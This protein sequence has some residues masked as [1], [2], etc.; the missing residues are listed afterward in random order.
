[1]S[2]TQDDEPRTF[3]PYDEEDSAAVQ[4]TLPADSFDAAT[5]DFDSEPPLV[6]CC[7]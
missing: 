7:G 2:D 6:G 4:A 3:P 5:A 1:M